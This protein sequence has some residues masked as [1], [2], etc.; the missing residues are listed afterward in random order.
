MAPATDLGR[1]YDRRFYDTI[2]N[3]CRTS[4][5]ATIAAVRDRLPIDWHVGHGPGTV[6]DVGCGEGWW[7]AQFQ[8]ML[9]QGFDGGAAPDAQIPVTAC[10]LTLPIPTS[11]RFDLAICLEVA[12]HLPELAAG[13]LVS[14]LVRLAPLV[15]FSAAMP[16]QGGTGHVNCQPPAYWADLFA[17]HG[18]GCDD[19]LR[20][21]IWD[22]PDVEPWYKS[23]LLL[24]GDR[25]PTSQ[26]SLG[27]SAGRL[28]RHVIH[29]DL[30]LDNR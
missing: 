3:G 29:P 10:D 16:R 21:D 15:L 14:E 26:P 27:R 4:A 9:V 24:F 23:N 18:Y 1:R 11:E 25:I 6:V 19:S 7:G 22:L 13:H 12:E 8:P 17:G 30:W 5:E 2:R 28:P 20:W